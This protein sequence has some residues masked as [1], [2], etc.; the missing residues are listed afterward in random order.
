[1]RRIAGLMLL[2]LASLVLGLLSVGWMLNH[3]FVLDMMRS[4]PWRFSLQAAADPD[5]YR[6]ARLVRS[7]G[8]TLALSEGLKLFATEDD[9]GHS[10]RPDCH[11][12]IRGNV[13]PSRYWT[14]S[15]A[16]AQPQAE[17]KATAR[18]GVTSSEV[19][20]DKVGD[21]SLELGPDVRAGVFL[22]VTG[23]APF[24]LVLNL[25]EPSILGGAAAISRDQLPHIRL[26]ACP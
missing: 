19:L 6:R 25:Y 13:T 12:H 21:W 3:E 26:E 8:V 1:M 7:G 4:G 11:Y 9:D 20:R 23:N 10:L 16:K 17:T 5:P 18:T 22:P 15:I 24:T 14:L 2:M